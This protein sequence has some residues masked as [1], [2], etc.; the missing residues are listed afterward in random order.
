MID[1]KACMH[2]LSKANYRFPRCNDFAQF[3]PPCK[4]IR[5][6]FARGIRN[7]GFWNLETVHGIRNPTND[8]NLESKFHRQSPAWNPESNTVLD[9]LMGQ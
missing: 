1:I 6:S 8:W 9:T 4:G 7:I 2:N 5:E 3:I